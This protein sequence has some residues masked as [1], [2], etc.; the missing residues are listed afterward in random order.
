MYDFELSDEQSMVL[1]TVKKL[2]QDV[3]EPVALE[4]DEHRQFVREG[5]D[6]LAELGLF[7]VAVAEAEGGAGLGLTS[8]ALALS[9]LGKGCGST[10]RMFLTQA[11][12]C[13]RALEGVAAAA[14]A[15]GQIMSGEAIGCWIGPEHRVTARADGDQ[16]VLDG[17]AR[18]AIA[19]TEAQLL[20]VAARLDDLPALFVVPVALARVAAVEALGF[21]GAAPG[22]VEFAA[23]QLAGETC[24]ARGDEAAA[25]IA[26]AALAAH[27]GAAALA[28][29]SAL[30]SIELGRRHAEERIAFG[31]P[32]ARQQAVGHKLVESR[33]RAEAGLLLALRAARSADRG[34][35][36][37]EAAWLAR[38][39]AVDAALHAADEAIQIHGGYGYTV[40]YHVERHYRDAKTLEVLD[41]GADA[42]RDALVQA[43]AARA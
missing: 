28:A 5:Y 13:A 7:G 16:F 24:V 19:A 42:L 27:I 34:E 35:D 26:R 14:D 43:M 17:S 37:R 9:E 36:A 1:D 15:A 32:L 8:L 2:V 41:G 31:K 23:V 18:I 38:L 20:L 40:E 3:V 6:G 22:S 4:R 39:T 29:G 11:A 12:L 10:G 21:H 30:E 25:A 33:R